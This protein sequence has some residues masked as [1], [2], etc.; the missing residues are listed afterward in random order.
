MN[1]FTKHFTALIISILLPFV[2]ISSYI[3]YAAPNDS[4]LRRSFSSDS[5]IIHC[6]DGSIIT[7]LISKNEAKASGSTGGTSTYI[8][9]KNGNTLWTAILSASF[10]YTG[11]SCTCTSASCQVTFQDSQ[12]SLK[13]K[14]V[15]KTGATAIASV[16][17]VHKVLGITISTNTQSLTLS[18]DVNGHLY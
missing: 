11:Y 8:C 4:D 10:D 13:S 16:T 2:F 15:N 7:V 9:S 5:N 18:C 12:Y 17:V 14:T 3:A 1:A 6:D